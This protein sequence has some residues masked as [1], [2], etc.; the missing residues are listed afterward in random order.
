MIK[1]RVRGGSMPK[2]PIFPMISDEIFTD[3]QDVL[4]LFWVKAEGILLEA[5]LSTALIGRRRLGKTEVLLRLYHRLFWEQDQIVPIYYNFEGKSYHSPDFAH[6][7]FKNFLS[8]YLAF[9][10][11]RNVELIRTPPDL[12]TLCEMGLD[13]G[14]LGLKYSIGGYRNLSRAGEINQ[15][16]DVVVHAPRNVSYE[17]D[18]PMLVILDEFQHVVQI[19]NP[20]GVDPNVIGKY[21]WGVEYRGAP[22]IVS[23][24][25]VTMMVKDI[26]GRGALF[27]RFTHEY[28]KPLD[29]YY[30]EELAEK[31]ARYYHLQISPEMAV[32]LGRRMGG[33]PF[34][35]DCVVRCARER[36]MDLTDIERLDQAIALEITGGAIWGDLNAQLEG[37][38]QTFNEHD[39]IKRILYEAARYEEKDIDLG[40][41]AER[42]GVD[43]PTV[44]RYAFHLSRAD[45]IEEG[46]GGFTY[47]NVK[48]PV[49]REFILVKARVDEEGAAQEVVY[50]DKM[51]AYRRLRGSF[52][53]FKGQVAE[54]YLQLLMKSFDG[55][56][57]DG[58]R[59]F[60]FPGEVVLPK[61]YY[62]LPRVV[63]VSGSRAYQIDL[64]GSTL[65]EAGRLSWLVE[66]KY[67]GEPVGIGE[68]KWFE[69][70]CEVAKED[71]E[72]DV[73]VPWF[74]SRSGFTEEAAAYLKEKGYLYSDEA[75]LN[76]LLEL[77]GLRKL[78]G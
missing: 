5:T 9:K 64:E 47:R 22:H 1:Q 49:L 68:V 61:F 26:L 53:H 60:H 70:A 41:I 38:V 65:V 31:L 73:L 58:E 35:I 33:N 48:D 24:S 76:G 71:L 11:G 42:V 52:S 63:K 43:F 27:Q 59:Y 32:E 50:R 45:L 44:R 29:E 19:R 66:S 30:A 7:Y 55:R 78:P 34:Y 4:D 25:A 13:F 40:K 62:V 8:Q 39:L 2:R 74:F 17:S 36:G 15:L 16:L 18:V 77:F 75:Q 54:V 28:L 14:D 21:Q 56:T 69:A 23:G 10:M 57:V 20:N 46:F 67:W 3:R 37:Y 51:E 12:E 6:D 72:I